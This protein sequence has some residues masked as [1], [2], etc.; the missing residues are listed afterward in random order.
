[1]NEEVKDN[2][3]KEEIPE[4]EP[5]NST[6][7][8]E[9]AENI[10]TEPEKSEEP[11]EKKGKSFFSRKNNKEKQKIEELEAEIEKLKA[12][13][14]EINDRF[15]RLYS[16]FDN[17]KKRV[18]K[19]KLDLISTAS[20]KVILSV[21]PIMDDFERAIGANEKAEDIAAVKEGFKLI[22]NKMQQMLSRLNVTEIEAVGH[23]FDTDVHEAVTHFPVEK[24]EDKGKVIDVTEKGYK[25]ADKVIRYAKV[26]VGQ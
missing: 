25:L 11:E 4:T 14:A 23:E 20:E 5:T 9:P 3:N 12:E 6:E 7:N 10:V 24:E 2:V 18:N 13:K 26:V 19:E 17:Y 16:E 8:T 21:L 22:Y 1:M 15:L